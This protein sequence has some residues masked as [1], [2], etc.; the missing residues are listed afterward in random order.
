MTTWKIETPNGTWER[1]EDDFARKIISN[2]MEIK[3]FGPLTITRVDAPPPPPKVV[4]IYLC[5][6]GDFEG[7][8]I[9]SIQAHMNAAH[10]NRKPKAKK[11]KR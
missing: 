11:G 9:R 10:G 3:V 5:P 8:G 6:K 4:R 7:E 1:A 2:L